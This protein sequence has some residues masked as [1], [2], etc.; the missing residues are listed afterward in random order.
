MT[1]LPNPAADIHLPAIVARNER[2][3]DRSFWT[4]LRKVAGQIPFAEDAA[5]AYFCA[6]DP[7]TPSKVKATLFAALAYFVLPFDVIPDFIVGI[8]FTDDAAVI[9]LAIGMVAKHIRPEHRARARA[10]LHIP[11][12]PPATKPAP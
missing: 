4:K 9:A 3:V 5:A 6:V 8:G 2:I 10:E 12:P 11:E 7:V 1:E